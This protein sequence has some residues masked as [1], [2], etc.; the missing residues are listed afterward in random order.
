M[1]NDKVKNLIAKLEVSGF[2][3]VRENLRYGRYKS[4][5]IPYVEDWI[6]EKEEKLNAPTCMYHEIKAPKGQHFKA[7]EVTSLEKKGWVDTPAKFRKGIRARA[8]RPIKYLSQF[9]LLHW[10]FIISFTTTTILTIIGIYLLWL[11]LIKT[12]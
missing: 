2:K 6:K 9:W 3:E 1:S 7:H 4:W 5:K 11:Q 8:R 10:K 12:K